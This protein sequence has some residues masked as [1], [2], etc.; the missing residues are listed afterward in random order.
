MTTDKNPS[1]FTVIGHRGSAGL[2]PEN[3]LASIRLALSKGVR[4][5]EIDLQRSKDGVLM[6]MHDRSVNRTTN[7]RGAV[8]ELT[9]SQLQALDA[10]SWFS[11]ELP[12]ELIP[13]LESALKLVHQAGAVLIVEVKYPQLYPGLAKELDTLIHN[14]DAS[15]N[16]L[17]MSFNRGFMKELSELNPDYPLGCLYVVP[18]HPKSVELS[19]ASYVSVFWRLAFLFPNRLRQLRA[20]GITTWAWTINRP[21]HIHQ[22]RK[23]GFNGVVTDFV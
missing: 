7:G 18:P 3:T 1:E 22:A 20:Q 14:I 4:Y 13:N 15:K 12:C 17:V 19:Y 16:V 10:G 9:W 8:S 6:I 2:A 5:V 11:P 21:D 23:Q